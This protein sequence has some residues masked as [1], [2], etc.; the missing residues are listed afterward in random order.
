MADWNKIKT[1][2]ITT[3]TSYR[4]LAQKYGV[5]VTNIAKKASK[6]DWVQQRNRNATATQTKILEAIGKQKAARAARLQ[7][8][9]DKLLCRVEA[10]VDSGDLVMLNT[11]SIK[12]ISGVLKD[13]KEIQMIRSDADMREQEARIRNLQKQAEKEENQNRDVTITIE[14]G[15][16]SWQS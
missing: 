16:P 14:G 3:D 2:Y 11:Q 7:T 5:N 8:V 4:K 12:H 6:E 15:D 13:I 1:E 10:L 9:A